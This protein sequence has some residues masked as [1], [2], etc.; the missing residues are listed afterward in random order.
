[1]GAGKGRTARAVSLPVL[2]SDEAKAE[3][4]DAERWYADIG[5]P[6]SERFVQAVEDT[7]R[8]IAEYP[9][10]FSTAYLDILAADAPPRRVFLKACFIRSK[11]T[12]FCRSPASTASATRAAGSAVKSLGQRLLVCGGVRVI[13]N[14]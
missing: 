13:G 1:M 14:R 2:W 9:L 6:L 12:E 10:R 11:P 8:L 7:V 3:F 5:L 4:Y